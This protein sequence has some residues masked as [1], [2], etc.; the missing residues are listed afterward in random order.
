MVTARNEKKAPSNR[1]HSLPFS[2]TLLTGNCRLASAPSSTV[3]SCYVSTKHKLNAIPEDFPRR[4]TTPWPDLP[5]AMSQSPLANSDGWLKTRSGSPSSCTASPR[6]SRSRACSFI[7]PEHT[8]IASSRSYETTSPTT[9]GFERGHVATRVKRMIPKG[10]GAVSRL[11]LKNALCVRTFAVAREPDFVL[12]GSHPA[13]GLMKNC[14]FA[15]QSR[16]AR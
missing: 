15:G 7:H 13:P 4:H 12:N 6:S 1:C 5:R 2:A 8:A 10:C 16:R 9:W 14:G 3:P 11:C